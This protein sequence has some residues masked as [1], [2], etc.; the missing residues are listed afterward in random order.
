MK[1]HP[2]SSGW[3]PGP[4]WGLLILLGGLWLSGVVLFV[5]QSDWLADGFAQEV[6]AILSWQHRS[7]VLHGLLAWCLCAWA[8]R[9]VWP[10]LQRFWARPLWRRPSLS[11]WAML[12]WLAGLMLSA[13]GLMYGSSDGHEGWHA[14]HV[15]PGLILPVLFYAHG[16]KPG[17]K[18][19]ARWLEA[20]SIKSPSG[21][22]PA[23]G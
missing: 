18:R 14:L 8:G 16:L 15:W 7:A 17:I 6:D 9:H 23:K 11:G 20:D 12:T 13:W 22:P 21:Q 19:Q 5:A 10:H 1:P 4:F 2:E 3:H